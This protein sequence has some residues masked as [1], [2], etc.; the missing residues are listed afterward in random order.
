[1]NNIRQSNEVIIIIII[2]TKNKV[3]NKAKNSKKIQTVLNYQSVM[4]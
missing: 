2:P 4:L 3:F 1:M